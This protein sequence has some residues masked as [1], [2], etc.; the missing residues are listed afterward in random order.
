MQ[1]FTPKNIAIALSIGTAALLITGFH[2]ESEKR[3]LNHR[4]EQMIEQ[5]EESQAEIKVV[6]K[7]SKEVLEHLRDR[8][9]IQENK[10]R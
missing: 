8:L 7:E 6:L 2:N 9:M 5:S 10:Q 3:K 1:L 4:F